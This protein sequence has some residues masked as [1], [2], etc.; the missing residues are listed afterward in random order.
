MT[1][2][3]DFLTIHSKENKVHVRDETPVFL[4]I[5][6]ASTKMTLWLCEAISNAF[7]LTLCI[8]WEPL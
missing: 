6:W 3:K 2:E 5:A 8:T 4:K 7:A 1:A